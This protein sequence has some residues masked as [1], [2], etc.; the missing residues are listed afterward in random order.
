MIKTT[1]SGDNDVKKAIE[2]L[3]S[4][5]DV[6]G[7]T[8][9]IHEGAEAPKSGD[10]NMATLGAI[11]HFGNDRIPARPWL[12]TGFDT[13]LK[14]YEAIISDAIESG[15]DLTSAMNRV[16]VVATGKVQQYITQLKSPPN[17]ESTI[18]KK[19]SSNPLIDTGAMRSSVS[20]QLTNE[21]PEE[22]L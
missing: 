16:G 4:S 9:G 6:P 5:L 14:E 2:D 10:I 22:G 18:K 7:V 17:A 3:I 15:D 8:V 20:Y 13:G 1:V 19:K 12:D 21:K 11:Q